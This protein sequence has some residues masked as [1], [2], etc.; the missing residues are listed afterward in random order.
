MELKLQS[1]GNQE[2]VTYVREGGLI[3]RH[4]PR[5]EE[6]LGPGF[7]ERA[8][9]HRVMSMGAPERCRAQGAHIFVTSLT[10]QQH[11]GE[12]P[13]ERKHSPFSDRRGNLRLIASPNGTAASL[14]LQQDVLIYSSVL[15]RGHHLVH[16]LRPG[17]GAW[18]HVVAGRLQLADQTL[19]SGDGAAL[20]DEPAVSFT[21]QDASEILLFDLA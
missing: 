8:D 1:N 14:R 3:V 16:E 20:D 21:A 7:Y 13:C 5:G 10:P 11:L 12:S 2:V 19:E 17:R 9:S 6:F 15:D 4:R 18:L